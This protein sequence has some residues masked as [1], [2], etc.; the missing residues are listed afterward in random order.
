MTEAKM[1]VNFDDTNVI[2]LNNEKPEFTSERE[3]KNTKRNLIIISSI[4]LLLVIIILIIVFISKI[5]N[6]NRIY[7]IIFQP[8][9]SLVLEPNH[10]EGIAGSNYTI[11]LTFTNRKRC[12]EEINLSFINSYN[13]SENDLVINIEK[14]PDK[15]LIV[16]YLVQYK[17]TVN[18]TENILSIKLNETELEENIRLKIT[19]AEFNHLEW[20]SGPTEGNVILP[21]II[22]FIPR[23]QYD[24]LY[25]DI[26]LNDNSSNFRYLETYGNNRHK[27]KK[28]F[29]DS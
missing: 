6:N 14:Y 25:T 4:L 29:L 9:D 1:N 5:N 7:H 27:S 2:I 21:P 18:D 19:N 3:N 23:D 15:C 8:K 10:I 24:N 12:K 11:N 13:L 20:I 17:M 16:L 28:E 26:F 22:T